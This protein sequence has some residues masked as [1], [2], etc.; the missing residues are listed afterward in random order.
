MWVETTGLLHACSVSVG[1]R[2][3]PN[4]EHWEVRLHLIRDI[5]N[6]KLKS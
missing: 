2:A 5:Y 4:R 6:I 1:G 3:T